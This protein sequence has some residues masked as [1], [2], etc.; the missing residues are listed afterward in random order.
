MSEVGYPTLEGR[1]LQS[2]QSATAF[3]NNNPT[4]ERVGYVPGSDSD[5]D[6]EGD[7]LASIM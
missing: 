2:L 3:L 7:Q 5:E 6:G 1:Q 4:A